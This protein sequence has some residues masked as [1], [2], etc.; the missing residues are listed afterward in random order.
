VKA[1]THKQDDFFIVYDADRV[2]H[3]EANLFDP[4]YWEKQG[5]VAGRARGRGCAWFLDTD[6]GAAV[7][8]QYLRGGWAARVSRD[9]YVFSGFERTRPVM[10]FRMLE[11]LGDAELPA[12]RPLAAMCRRDGGFYFG[13]ILTQRI[14]RGEPLAEQ[15][16]D[17]KGDQ[18][19][20]RAVGACI[21]R[22]HRFGLVHADLNAR[23]I[24]VDEA[25][26]IHL[27][28]F[29]RSRISPGNERA[30]DANLARL[31][32]SLEK[33]WPEPFHTEL[34][35]CWLQLSEG[36]AAGDRNP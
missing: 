20:W 28:D 18:M 29:D 2:R 14:P 1:R 35:S 16:A 17:R 31:R 6:F 15:V 27:I 32:R 33:V 22:F 23:N 8:K 13:W 3:P 19:I 21:R 11:K 9:R 30:F 34:E 25:G 26:A 24:L 10:E 7:L 36:Y 5:A 12:P 4:K